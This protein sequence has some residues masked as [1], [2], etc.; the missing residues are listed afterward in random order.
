LLVTG[1]RV[2]QVWFRRGQMGKVQARPED[3]RRS[4]GAL[5]RYNEG[6]V[7]GRGLVWVAVRVEYCA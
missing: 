6:F 4:R 2:G 3:R 1:A 5:S 7:G